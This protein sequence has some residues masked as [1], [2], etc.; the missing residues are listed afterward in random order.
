MRL[1][2]A[3][4][5]PRAIAPPDVDFAVVQKGRQLFAHRCIECHTLPPV[6]RYDTEE[7]P[8]IVNAMHR[9]ALKPAERGAI[10]SYILTI[11]SQG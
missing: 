9:A 7:W 1:H 3:T 10:L 6:W 5:S 8:R 2:F 11:R 4:K